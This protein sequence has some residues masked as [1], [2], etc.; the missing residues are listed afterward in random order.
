MEPQ[1]EYGKS[2]TNNMHK[3]HEIHVSQLTKPAFEQIAKRDT[4][5][6]PKIFIVVSVPAYLSSNIVVNELFFSDTVATKCEK[7]DISP[8]IAQIRNVF[9]RCIGS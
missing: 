3:R 9:V 6:T 4:S 1:S 2:G 5:T 7:V 8:R